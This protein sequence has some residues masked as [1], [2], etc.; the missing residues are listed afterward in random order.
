MMD[1]EDKSEGIISDTSKSI[2]LIELPYIAKSNSEDALDAIGGLNT[3]KAA[4]L[5]TKKNFRVGFCAKG[6]NQGWQQTL[7]ADRRASNGLLLKM[8]RN[9]RT[10]ATSCETIGHVT[11]SY[12]FNRP[13]DF[14][15]TSPPAT[16]ATA[17]ATASKESNAADALMNVVPQ[18]FSVK[19][20]TKDAN[21]F[22]AE[23]DLS[24]LRTREVASTSSATHFSAVLVSAGD[25]IPLDPKVNYFAGR[26]I[27]PRGETM[28]E[29]KEMITKMK[30]LFNKRPAWEAKMMKNHPLF[31]TRNHRFK[32]IMP[33]QAYNVTSGPFQHAWVRWGYDPAADHQSRHYQS[34]QARMSNEIFSDLKIGRAHV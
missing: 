19:V 1:I 15:F 25:P 2:I 7:E 8:K 24:A 21:L 9:K 4:I 16:E 14:A 34:I 11:H 17:N 18:P 29:V 10:N 6:T 5:E 12:H 28:D 22:D 20:Q 3:V 26:R 31:I 13:A 30:E 27:G 32:N 23:I 33:F